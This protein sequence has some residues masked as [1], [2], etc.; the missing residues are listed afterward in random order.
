MDRIP[1]LQE[2]VPVLRWRA[3]ILWRRLAL[4]LR[5]APDPR[6]D[7]IGERLQRL[8]VVG[9]GQSR[10]LRYPVA[11]TLHILIFL[12]FLVLLF[13][14]LDSQS[15]QGL[16]LAGTIVTALIADFLLEL[17]N[18]RHQHLRLDLHPLQKRHVSSHLIL[19]SLLRER[20][21]PRSG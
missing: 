2:S 8:P 20:T 15:T 5:A 21:A 14:V 17:P 10:Q 18:Q 3:W 11:G 4:L 7:R 6:L 13:S 19:R 9:L 1:R 16:L 12:G